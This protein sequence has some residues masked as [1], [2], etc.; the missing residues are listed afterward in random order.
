MF[1]FPFAHFFCY[2]LLLLER[3]SMVSSLLLLLSTL[4]LS[5]NNHRTIAGRH[6]IL[7]YIKS[8][9]TKKALL[10]AV[11]ILKEPTVE[12]N[13]F[14]VVTTTVIVLSLWIWVFNFCFY[15]LYLTSIRFVV[16]PIIDLPLPQTSRSRDA[17]QLLQ[18]GCKPSCLRCAVDKNRILKK[19]PMRKIGSR[20]TAA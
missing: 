8:L 19:L 3:E 16:A 14:V 6:V 2:C 4:S 20:A 12:I 9:N 17:M 5:Y 15:F 13:A 10:Q 1:I 7:S 18:T 11:N